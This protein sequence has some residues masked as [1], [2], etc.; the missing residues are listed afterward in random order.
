MAFGGSLQRYWYVPPYPSLIVTCMVVANESEVSNRR[1]LRRDGFRIA[2]ERA[3]SS[4]GET[5]HLRGPLIAVESYRSSVVLSA[6]YSMNG[7]HWREAV[8]GVAFGYLSC[9]SRRF[10]RF[11]GS[12]NLSECLLVCIGATATGWIPYAP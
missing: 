11:F 12:D 5:I 3:Y 4:E 8:S 9:R 2:G 10:H 1:I 7:P 6:P